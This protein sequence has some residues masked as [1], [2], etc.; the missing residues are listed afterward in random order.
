MEDP[1]ITTGNFFLYR[2]IFLY[3]IFFSASI[4]FLYRIFFL[5]RFFFCI[6]FFFCIELFFF[7]IDFF[8]H[9]IFFLYLKYFSLCRAI[10]ARTTWRTLL[11]SCGMTSNP[12]TSCGPGGTSVSRRTPPTSSSYGKQTSSTH[13]SVSTILLFPPFETWGETL[14]S[15]VF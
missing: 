4:F 9:L 2:V 15:V 14:Y 7:C 13:G 11:T 12:C 6:D 5:H 10:W 8:L 1:S 3:R